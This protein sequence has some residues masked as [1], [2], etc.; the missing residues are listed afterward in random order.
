MLLVQASVE[1]ISGSE[2]KIKSLKVDHHLKCLAE[3][4]EIFNSTFVESEKCKNLI[5]NALMLCDD[6]YVFNMS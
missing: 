3:C 1:G 6:I 2:A 5:G 4:E